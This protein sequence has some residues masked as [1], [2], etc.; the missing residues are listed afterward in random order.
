MRTRKGDRQS[1]KLFSQIHTWLTTLLLNEVYPQLI[2]NLNPFQTTDA[3]WT[4]LL[5]SLPVLFPPSPSSPL[6]LCYSIYHHL[7]YFTTHLLHFL[8]F[9]VYSSVRTVPG[10]HVNFICIYKHIICPKIQHHFTNQSPSPRF[11]SPHRES[12]S[13]GYLQH[14]KARNF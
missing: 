12:G 4:F 11:L 1:L 2:H 8:C 7:I 6:Y 13:Q 9:M 10:I 14:P 3:L 5:L